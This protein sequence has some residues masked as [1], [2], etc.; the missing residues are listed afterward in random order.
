M[1]LVKYN[2]CAGAGG[3]H[4]ALFFDE[5]AFLKSFKFHFPSPKYFKEPTIDLTCCCKKDLD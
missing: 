1:T 4:I 5:N 3:A 2:P